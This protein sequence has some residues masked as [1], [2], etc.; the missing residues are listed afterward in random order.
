MVEDVMGWHEI[1][2]V[3]TEEQASVL[4]DQLLLLGAEAITLKDAGNHPI[5]EPAFDLTPSWKQTA[6]TALFQA[7]TDLTDTKAYLQQQCESGSIQ[8][9]EIQFLA[10]EDWERRCLDNL[11]PMS[12]GKRLVICPSWKTPTDPDAVTIILDP[13]LAFGTGT[14]ATTALCLEWLDEHVQGGEC[15]VDYGCGSG[16]LGIAAIKLGAQR[17]IAIDHDARA[18]EVTLA[19]AKDN[20]LSETQLSASLP[21]ANFEYQADLFVANILAQPL[22]RLAKHFASLTKPGGHILLSGILAEQAHAVSTAYL[23][24]FDMDK[25]VQKD[26]WVRLTG[27]RKQNP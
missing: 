4:E 16:I 8:Q 19:N 6:L 13:G 12:F 21:I 5:Y 14:H 23:P 26:E 25:P 27:T 1:H 11:E 15:I 24:W 7:Q 2:I 17:V 18:V 9:F 20:Q 22:L 10:D 3:T